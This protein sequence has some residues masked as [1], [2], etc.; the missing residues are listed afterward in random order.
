VLTYY[1]LRTYGRGDTRQVVNLSRGPRPFW[2]LGGSDLTMFSPTGL[3]LKLPPV[4]YVANDFY[5]PQ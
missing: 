1:R 5:H 3:Q 4:V 2:H